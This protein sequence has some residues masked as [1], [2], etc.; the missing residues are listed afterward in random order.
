M[1]VA[2][3][4]LYLRARDTLEAFP[5]PGTDEDP[6]DPFF[7]PDGQ[8]I[9]YWSFE[10][11]QLKKIPIGGGAP[12]ILTDAVNPGGRPS[13]G[14][15]NTIVF[16][17][18]E[19]IMR[20]SADGGA[21]EVLVGGSSLRDPQM[22]PGEAILY[23]RGGPLLGEVVVQPLESGE[24]TVLFPGTQPSY[25]PTGHLIYGL[26]NA[27]FAVPFD[28]ETLDVTGGQV[29]VVDLAR[30]N[31]MHY[32]VSDSGTL[33]YIQ[34]G[35]TG[36]NDSM[37]WVDRQ[38]GE[39]TLVPADADGRRP[40]PLG[41]YWDPKFSPDGRQVVV[42]DRKD[43][44]DVWVYD[45]DRATLARLTFD[46]VEDHTP[47]WSPDGR[48]IAYASAKGSEFQRAVYRK[49]SDGTGAEESLWE[50]NDHAHVTGWTPD[51]NALL[52]GIS[53]G[54]GQLGD[55]WLLTLDDEPTAS[56][57]I[58][59]PFNETLARLS[60]D[61]QWLA[62]VSDESGRPEIFAQPFPDLDGKWQVSNGGGT[63]PVWSRSGRELFYR[64]EGY[65]MAVDIPRDS[66]VR[67]SVPRRLFQDEYVSRDAVGHIYY[68]IA[69][70]DERFL[71]VRQRSDASPSQIN[72]VLS[73]FEELKERV[74]VP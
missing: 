5:V 39:E 20:V 9:G 74:P 37:V 11:R 6:I 45:L 73:W 66:T 50:S 28:A 67:P 31:E 41:S 69:S 13:W 40:I 51:G 38:G 64:G 23:G 58:Q 22:L 32:S 33:A 18:P 17:Q 26:E 56:P 62:Y 44:N 24:P 68:D 19:G 34:G 16:G 12:V 59:T 36:Q 7:S 49:R 47:V 43:G 42:A 21:P 65:L 53:S 70:D 25:V 52:L 4:Q 57:F 1:Y 48:W 35:G 27:L 71:I 3:S 61:G 54:A 63:Q 72:V 15:D 2:N 10:D 14:N 46:D 30:I 60:P 55:I 8:W 29:S